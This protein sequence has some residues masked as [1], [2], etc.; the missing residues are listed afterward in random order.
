MF[1]IHISYEHVHQTKPVHC[2][3]HPC[4]NVALS[5][6]VNKS[7]AYSILS[8]HHMKNYKLSA[9]TALCSLT[10]GAFNT[11]L[12][13]QQHSYTIQGSID[14]AYQG[15]IYLVDETNRQYVPID[16]T[17]VKDGHYTFSGSHV[18]HPRL[19]FI[20]TNA[21]YGRRTCP[22]FLEDGTTRIKTGNPAYI[23]T[24]D[25]GGTLDNAIF[26]AY[27]ADITYSTKDSVVNAA[28]IEAYLTPN[29]SQE[30]Q[31]A[32]FEQRS[33]SS[34]AR[35]R[36]ITRTYYERY[37]QQ[38]FGLMLL[39]NTLAGSMTADELRQEVAAVTPHFTEHPYISEL[40]A[41]CAAKSVSIG[42]PAPDFESTDATGKSIRLSDFKGQYVLLDFWASWCGP[43]RREIPY[44]Q[45]AHRKYGER[46]TILSVSLD[47][48]KDAWLQAVQTLDMPWHHV[49]DLK[50]WGSDAAVKYDVN[51]IP[52]TFLIGP[53]GLLIATGLRGE[54]L[55]RTLAKHLSK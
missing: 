22:F 25:L 13:A 17:E 28:R 44:I 19:A 2:L 24:S 33:K 12:H 51:A 55:E 11:T 53:D 3:N 40:Q 41:M 31:S 21:S 14:P 5:S 26:H 4:G 29:L 45:A 39:R 52:K 46:L 7:P 32:R 1:P 35:A 50:A 8:F 54:A 36:A 43:C 16:S 23:Y 48:K 38:P 6:P 42:A 34:T 20:M 30:E 15:K 18:E 49:C 10:F 37:K 27:R 9:I 47:D